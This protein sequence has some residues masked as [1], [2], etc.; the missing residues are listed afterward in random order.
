MTPDEYIEQRIDVKQVIVMRTDL[1]MRK[2]KF[3][4][5]GSHASMGFVEELMAS[6]GIWSPDE[7]RWLHS[8][9]H[10]KIVCKVR[11]EEELMAVHKAALAAGLKSHLVIDFGLTEFKGVRTATCI[12][13]GPAQNRYIDPITGHLELL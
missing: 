1:N 6:G 4:G 3:V 10:P 12:G 7:L 2:G 13:I 5:Q 8:P 9:G 11:S